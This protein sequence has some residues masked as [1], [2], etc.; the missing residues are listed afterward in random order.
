M[1]QNGT[2]QNDTVLQNG[3]VTK[4][5]VVK[6]RYMLHGTLKN[7]HVIKWYT[8]NAVCTKRYSDIMVLATAFKDAKGLLIPIV[9]THEAYI[10][11][12]SVQSQIRKL[13]QTSLD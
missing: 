5:T 3:T 9:F 13:H 4:W 10:V 2:L 1:L 12:N 7:C 6:R 11:Q 8:V